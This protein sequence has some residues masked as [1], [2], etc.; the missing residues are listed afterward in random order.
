MLV[1]NLF[2][3]PGTGKSTGMAYIFSKLKMKGINAE[4]ASE[5]AKD[6]VWE[7]GT[8]S[9]PEEESKGVFNSQIY[10][11]GKQNF[12]LS[13]LKNKVDVIITDSPILLSMIYSGENEK[14]YK[15]ELDNLVL[16][17]F[18]TYNNYNVFLNRVKEYHQEGRFQNESEAKIIDE[19]VKELLL[20]NKIKFDSFDGS[21]DGYDKI[22]ERIETILEEKTISYK[23]NKMNK[24]KVDNK[25]N[26]NDNKDNSLQKS[27]T[28]LQ[29]LQKIEKEKKNKI[30]NEKLKKELETIRVLEEKKEYWN[31]LMPVKNCE[32]VYN[33]LKS[34]ER[35]GEDLSKIFMYWD[36][37]GYYEVR[38]EIVYNELDEKDK[39]IKKEE[40]NNIHAMNVNK[41][42][43]DTGVRY[44]AFG[45]GGYYKMYGI[46]DNI[47]KR[48][49]YLK[50]RTFFDNKKIMD[51]IQVEF[52]NVWNKLVE[53]YSD[54]MRNIL[55]WI[56]YVNV[57]DKVD[58]EI[59]GYVF[60][61]VWE[62]G[63]DVL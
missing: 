43:V 41:P 42:Y 8:S 18:N 57:N 55:G 13:R 21:I 28:L 7:Y 63:K 33:T 38:Q 50:Y 23:L 59:N 17:V 3:G 10:I 52:W 34:I 36:Y 5:F 20:N 62:L 26:N 49:K 60:V 2:A 15:N 45:F 53:K 11:F 19:K 35:N 25:N 40:I 6:K 14:E 48:N 4:I 1:V 51:N 24:E 54:E 30:E 22:V 44:S 31:S 58:R 39:A 29:E 46:D 12:K 37:N 27:G 9:K 56:D 47:N 16:K 61:K 32:D